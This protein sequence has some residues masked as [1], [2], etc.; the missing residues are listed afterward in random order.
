MDG[1]YLIII[2]TSMRLLINYK[3]INKI[4][5]NVES[6]ASIV[7]FIHENFFLKFSHW[8]LTYLDADGDRITLESEYDVQTMLE[9]TSKDH[10]KAFIQDEQQPEPQ[11]QPKVEQEESQV[12][13]IKE[14]KVKE[15]V[16]EAVEEEKEVVREV[17][18]EELEEEK[19]ECGKAKC[20]NSWKKEW[21]R[22]V[23]EKMAKLVDERVELLIP[24]ITKKVED[25]IKGV[26]HVSS[27]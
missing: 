5:P 1:R 27:Q 4:L 10:L 18:V 26:S 15:E 23:E 14:L 16:K 13:I 2:F 17:N 9:T 19:G 25:R 6:Y 12:E 3:G 20:P 22:K 11:K 8:T 21:K 24:C 7:K